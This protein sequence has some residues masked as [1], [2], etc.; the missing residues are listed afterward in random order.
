[1]FR[2]KTLL[3]LALIWFVHVGHT[4]QGRGTISGAVTD[5]TGAAVK[6]ARVTLV[7]TNTNT[8]SST[9]SNGDGYYTFPP[10][11]VGNYEVSAESAGFKK[12][13][14]RGINLQVDQSAEISLQL[15][16]GAASW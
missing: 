12:E 10:Q 3:S 7:N 1:M 2:L 9:V 8:S 13:I 6:G 4:Q 16:L 5:Q 14:R 15:Q 11:I